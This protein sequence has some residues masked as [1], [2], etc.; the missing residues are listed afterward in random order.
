MLKQFD[1]VTYKI[2]LRFSTVISEWIIEYKKSMCTFS[3]PKTY[4]EET[5][6]LIIKLSQKI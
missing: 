4:L 2:G 6:R 3:G 1:F 5:K